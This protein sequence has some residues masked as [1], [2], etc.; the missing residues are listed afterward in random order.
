MRLRSALDR[1]CYG[2]T[3][4]MT[5][6]LQVAN[7]MREAGGLESHSCRQAGVAWNGNTYLNLIRAVSSAGQV[8]LALRMLGRMRSDGVR[9]GAAHYTCPWWQTGSHMHFEAIRDLKIYGD[10]APHIN[11]KGELGF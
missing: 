1:R 2:S 3:G 8:E 5:L 9:P 7:R 11:P 6:A 4:Q 10:V